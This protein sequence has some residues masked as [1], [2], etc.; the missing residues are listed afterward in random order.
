MIEYIIC[1]IHKIEIGK[2]QF[3]MGLFNTVYDDIYIYIF[4]MSY[5]TVNNFIRTWKQNDFIKFMNRD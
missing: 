2:L 1:K 3:D 5:V 4:L